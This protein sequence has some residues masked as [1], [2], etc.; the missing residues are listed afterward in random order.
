MINNIKIIATKELM[1]FFSTPI[2]Y[3]FL[4]AYVTL[5]NAFAFY[6]GNFFERGTAS[7]QAFFNFQPWIFLLFI[8]AITMKMWSEEKKSGTVELLLTMPFHDIEIVLGKF[9]GALIFVTIGIIFTFPMWISVNILG[10]PDNMVIIS[11][12]IGSILLASVFIAI[13]L[14]VSSLSKNQIVSFILSMMIFFVYLLSGTNVVLDFFYQ[15]LPILAEFISAMS[16]SYHFNFFTQGSI[17][18]K[19][20]GFFILS[21]A[22]WISINFFIIKYK[23]A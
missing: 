8:S 22:F 18:I 23:R 6:I 10:E 21:L 16:I 12:Y 1:S 2:A 5:S 15:S 13:G 17:E 20:I 3:I 7:L 19:S 4:I 11:S 9:F 14:C